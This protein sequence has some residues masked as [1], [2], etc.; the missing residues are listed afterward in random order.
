MMHRK[1]TIGLL[2]GGALALTAGPSVAQK[3]ETVE[4]R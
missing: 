4:I 1:T 3:G 2:I